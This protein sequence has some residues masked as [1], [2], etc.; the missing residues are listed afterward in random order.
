MCLLAVP[1]TAFALSCFHFM[2]LSVTCLSLASVGNRSMLCC[3]AW[4]YNATEWTSTC[5]V[6]EG[7]GG[8]CACLYTMPSRCTRGVQKETE[9]FNS[10]STSIERALRLLSTRSVRFWQQTAICPIS[11]WA[12]VI[13]LHPLNW[14]RAQAAL[15]I[16]G[17]DEIQ[18]NAIR[19]LRT[20]TESAFQEALQQ[21]KKC[22]ER[23]IAS[24]GDCFEGDSA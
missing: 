23:C 17:K 12:L 10:T 8:V 18:E 16:S 19:E 7:E 1:R 9:L 3:G 5:A 20:I 4:R 15:Q 22:W 6:Q 11:L 13:E 21:W 14:A 2:M 24:R